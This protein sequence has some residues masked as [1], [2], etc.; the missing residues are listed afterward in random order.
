[1]LTHPQ[2]AFFVVGAIACLV[3]FLVAPRNIAHIFSSLYFLAL[4]FLLTTHAVGMVSREKLS[5]VS[6][7]H[8]GRFHYSI[9]ED[10]LMFWV[11]FLV[12]VGLVVALLAR[13]RKAYA[14]RHHD[15]A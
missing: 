7:R 4:S 3:I 6:A 12:Q 15:A 8:G 10:P 5:F 1:M 9:S 13:A 11:V 2:G 14:T